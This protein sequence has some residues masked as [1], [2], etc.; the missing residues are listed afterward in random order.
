MNMVPRNMSDTSVLV[1]PNA[2]AVAVL[3]YPGDQSSYSKDQKANNR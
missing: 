3:P 2:T 1:Q